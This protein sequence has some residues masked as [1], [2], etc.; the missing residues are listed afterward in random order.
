MLSVPPRS[1]A[2]YTFYIPRNSFSKRPF[3]SEETQARRPRPANSKACLWPSHYVV[4][5][6]E[7]RESAC[8][9]GDNIIFPSFWRKFYGKAYKNTSLHTSIRMVKLKMTKNTKCGKDVE[10]MEFP[11]PGSGWVHRYNLF[12]NRFGRIYLSWTYACPLTQQVPSQVYPTDVHQ[13][14]RT[15]IFTIAL[16][17]K[18]KHWKLTKCPLKPEWKNSLVILSSIRM[19]GPQLHATISI[20]NWWRNKG[21]YCMTPFTQSSKTGKINLWC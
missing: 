5:G 16:F 21:T 1:W 13:K 3:T 18:A 12:G 14:T 11:H 19:N 8:S 7:G 17:I 20:Q 15:R 2:L 9:H 10:Q 4:S 6:K